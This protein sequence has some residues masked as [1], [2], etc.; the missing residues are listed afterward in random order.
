MLGMPKLPMTGRY[1]DG[2][3]GEA[4]AAPAQV[5]DC[6]VLFAPQFS[7]DEFALLVAVAV[8]V[9][10]VVVE[11]ESAI[12]AEIN[13]LDPGKSSCQLLRRRSMRWQ[14]ENRSVAR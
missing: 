3:I 4:A 7:G 9:S 1:G 6:D 13:P 2:H 14:A 5:Q 12:C 11:L 8:S 10:V